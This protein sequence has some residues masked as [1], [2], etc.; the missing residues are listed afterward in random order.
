M[1]YYWQWITICGLAVLAGCGP[2]GTR[3]ELIS[4][5]DGGVPQHHYAEFPRAYFSRSPGGSLQLVLRSDRPSN[6]DPTQNITQIVYIKT[7]WTARP[8]TTYAEATQINSRIQ[9]A[10]LTPPT[11]IRY[12]GGAFLHYKTDRK[13]KEMVGTIEG[14]S[15]SPRYRMGNA[16]DPFGPSRINGTFRAK[17]DRGKVAETLQLL[18]T[19]FRQSSP[20][21][22]N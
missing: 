1:K 19:Q 2:K 11:G 10:M 18:E 9:Y 17:E 8:G 16:A 7:F 4:F 6:I 3:I 20:T 14:G 22:R 21:V 13:T 12:D 5:D 15:I